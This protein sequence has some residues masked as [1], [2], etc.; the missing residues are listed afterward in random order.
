ME[1]Y[2]ANFEPDQENSGNES[3][4][5]YIVTGGIIV[6]FSTLNKDLKISEINVD[7]EHFSKKTLDN[8]IKILKNNSGQYNNDRD[9]ADF[10]NGG[11]FMDLN[12]NI[13]TI[14]TN[15][16]GLSTSFS[17]VANLSL[18]QMFVNMRTFYK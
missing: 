1:N 16:F 4:Q 10:G 8:F 6:F 18:L 11:F 12:K 5:D 13:L 3:D 2:E 17:V 14:S 15:H 9:N 7:F